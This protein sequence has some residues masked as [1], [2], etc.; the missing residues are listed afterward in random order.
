MSERFASCSIN[1]F[2][3]IVEL[4]RSQSGTVC[5]GVFKYDQKE[6]ILKERKLPELG[7]SKDIMNEVKLLLQLN[8][9]NVIKCEGISLMLTYSFIVF[10]IV[11]KT[12][13]TT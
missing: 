6:Y 3:N 11:I 4:Y 9:T 2:I 8:H 7:R 12:T 1:D 13:I 10:Y 5:K